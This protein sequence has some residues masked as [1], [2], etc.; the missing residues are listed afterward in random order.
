M[1]DLKADAADVA[2]ATHMSLILRARTLVR[3]AELTTQEHSMT[4]PSLILHMTEESLLSSS[5]EQE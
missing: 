2:D 1:A 3:L 5:A 4:E